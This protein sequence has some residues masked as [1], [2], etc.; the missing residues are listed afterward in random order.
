MNS[1]VHGT[2]DFAPLDHIIITTIKRTANNI[3]SVFILEYSIQ[4]FANV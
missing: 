2:K 4:T 3:K 1:T